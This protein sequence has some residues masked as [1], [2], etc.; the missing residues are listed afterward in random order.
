[1]R[2]KALSSRIHHIAGGILDHDQ[3]KQCFKR[4]TMSP[5]LQIE[6][7]SM[8][9]A[10]YCD[11][12]IQ[13]ELH[14]LLQGKAGAQTQFWSNFVIT[15]CCGYLEYKVKVNKSQSSNNVSMQFWWRKPNWFRRG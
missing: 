10:L 1:M 13:A 12:L 15:K 14:L 8:L 4:K 7:A 6:S 2:R 9:T 11:T 3:L 5:K